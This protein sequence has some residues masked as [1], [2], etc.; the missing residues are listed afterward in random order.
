MHQI[1]AR[2]ELWPMSQTEVE[3]RLARSM[4]LCVAEHVRE[5]YAGVLD[6]KLPPQIA[7]LLRR[8]DR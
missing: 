7:M 4:R 8:L 1:K 6:E 5:L 3:E 2:R